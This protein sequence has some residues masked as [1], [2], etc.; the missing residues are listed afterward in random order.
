MN[1]PTIFNSLL[2]SFSC[3]RMPAA[4][5]G[6]HPVFTK[7]SNGLRFA[8]PPA[9]HA[10][11]KAG[12]Q[13]STLLLTRRPSLAYSLGQVELL[14]TTTVPEAPP[15]GPTSEPRCSLMCGLMHDRCT[16]AGGKLQGHA[17]L[18]DGPS[19]VGGA[20][21]IASRLAAVR[22]ATFTHAVST[23][24]RHVWLHLVRGTKKFR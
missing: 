2:F 4:A 21:P 13:S 24:V 15:T 11:F 14:L 7:A 23:Y 10:S 5:W 20:I 16:C 19:G 17:S 22:G 9:N 6:L 8:T 3:K 12:G 1:L 18:A